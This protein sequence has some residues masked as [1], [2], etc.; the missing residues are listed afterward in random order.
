MK[1]KTW[2]NLIA[3]SVTILALAACSPNK[4][5]TSLQESAKPTPKAEATVVSTPTNAAPAQPVPTPA[6]LSFAVLG[7]NAELMNDEQVIKYG[8]KLSGKTISAW[9]GRV[10]KVWNPDPNTSIVEIEMHYDKTTPQ[11]EIPDVA[12]KGLSSADL[13]KIKPGEI[14]NFAGII[15]GVTDVDKRKNMFIIRD[16]ILCENK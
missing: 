9:T 4:P 3:G 13:Q 15:D 12:L 5:Q 8:E 7:R 14:V 1:N 16:S 10:H 11:N 6:G 2:K